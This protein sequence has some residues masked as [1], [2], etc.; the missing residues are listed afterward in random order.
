MPDIPRADGSQATVWTYR[1]GMTGWTALRRSVRSHQRA[2]DIALAV[3]LLCAMISATVRSGNGEFVVNAPTVIIGVLICGALTVRRRWPVPVLVITTVGVMAAIIATDARTPYSA[4]AAVAAYTVAMNTDRKV[5]WTCGVI[6]AA[7]LTTTA[8]LSSTEFWS[9][10]RNLEFI[11]WVTM[12]TAI[13]DARRSRRAYV[14]AIEERA[15]RAEQSKEEEAGRQVAEERL[16]IARELHDIVAHH[17]ALINVQAGVATHMLRTEPDAAAEALGHVRLAART[18]LDELSTV[19]GVLRQPNDSGAPYEP[20]P[21]MADL[22]ALVDTFVQAGLRIDLTTSGR[23]R[24]V[25]SAVD[26]AAYRIIQESLTNAQKYGD[27]TPVAVRVEHCPEALH[28]EVLNAGA[29]PPKNPSSGGHGLI[30]MHE[31]AASVGGTLQASARPTGDFL[32]KATL[33]VPEKGPQ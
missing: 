23:A 33:P 19:L 28:I 6:V 24:P 13:G 9:N 16:R 20:A 21:G 3:L 5:A 29:W 4:V 31:R 12:A 10:P 2:A 18:V 25:P 8:M 27:G 15:I 11:A 14:A 1:Q 22:D 32:V 26:L 30:G 7:A 17:I